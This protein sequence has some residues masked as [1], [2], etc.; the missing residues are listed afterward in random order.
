M[1]SRRLASA[2]PVIGICCRKKKKKKAAGEKKKEK[3]ERLRDGEVV[4]YVSE[5]SRLKTLESSGDAVG[6]FDTIC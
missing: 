4:L 5:A 3:K 1:V 6:R 2:K